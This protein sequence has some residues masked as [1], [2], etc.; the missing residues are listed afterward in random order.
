MYFVPE[1]NCVEQLY[2]QCFIISSFSWHILWFHCLK[3]CPFH[4]WLGQSETTNELLHS[5]HVS[6]LPVFNQ[7]LHLLVALNLLQEY[8][9]QSSTE[10]FWFLMNSRVAKALSLMQNQLCADHQNRPWLLCLQNVNYGHIFAQNSQRLRT[11][12]SSCYRTIGKI[13]SH[14]RITA[15]G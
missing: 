7:I 10:Y 8:L 6:L 12:P 1:T 14:P 11:C 15:L 13:R 2:A 3:M 4:F 5:S 9:I